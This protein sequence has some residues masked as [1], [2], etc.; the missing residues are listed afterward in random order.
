MIG[1]AG[2]TGRG[3][4]ARELVRRAQ[5]WASTRGAEVQLFDASLVIGAE[6]L[7]VAAEKAARAFTEGRNAAATRSLE[8]LLYASGERQLTAAL[9]KMGVKDGTEGIAAIVWDADP[10][11]LLQ[12]LG[13]TPDDRVLTASETKLRA[14]GMTAM[15]LSTIPDARRGDLILE[16]V[17][18]V[19][20][21]KR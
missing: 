20:V 18:L 5:E 2:G 15:E 6:H 12:A 10:H 21:L 17:A 19:D 16:R 14:F 4:Q 13:L 11:A 7:L 9:E 8:T 3:V 1:V